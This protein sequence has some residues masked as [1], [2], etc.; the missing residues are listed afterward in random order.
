MIWEAR[1]WLKGSKN[2]GGGLPH[3]INHWL[4]PST[5]VKCICRWKGVF[6]IFVGNLADSTAFSS[7][8]HTFKATTLKNACLAI[9]VRVNSL[10]TSVDRSVATASSLGAATSQYGIRRNRSLQSFET[11]ESYTFRTAYQ[12][13]R[14]A[15]SSVSLQSLISF[16]SAPSLGVYYFLSLTLSACLSGC[17][18]VTEIQIDDS[19]FCFSSHFWLSV[20]HEPLYKTLFFDFWFTPHNAQNLL[21]KIWH[22]IAYKSA[23][24]ADRPEMFGPNRGPTRGGGDACCHNDIWP[25]RGVQSPTGLSFFFSPPNLRGRSV[26]RHQILTH[27]LGGDPYLWNWVRRPIPPKMRYKIPLRFCV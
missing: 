11:D 25:R 21:P 9:S 26:D 15:G 4:L 10:G 20:L 18:I 12:L 5:T 3:H 19:P 24:M 6:D 16:D 14:D 17:P 7:G 8:F 27:V 2:R 13:C 1:H 22:K 23:S